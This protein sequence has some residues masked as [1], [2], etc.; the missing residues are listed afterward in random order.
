MMEVLAAGIAT[1]FAGYLFFHPARLRLSRTEL[2]RIRR[3]SDEMR[4]TAIH[5]FEYE[6]K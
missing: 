5:P 6:S 1:A 2:P 3:L 4:R